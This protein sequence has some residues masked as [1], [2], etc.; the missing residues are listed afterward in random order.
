MILSKHIV[1]QYVIQCYTAFYNVIQC[2][3]CGMQLDDL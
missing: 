2:F 3:Q 1:L